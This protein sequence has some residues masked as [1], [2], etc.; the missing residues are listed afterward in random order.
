MD[1]Q[2]LQCFSME[3]LCRGVLFISKKTNKTK[4]NG[5]GQN[6]EVLFH[7]FLPTSFF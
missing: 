2:F 4:K 3:G 6:V 1:E 5:K 7:M